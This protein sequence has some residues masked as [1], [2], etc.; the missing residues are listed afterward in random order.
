MRLKSITLVAAIA[1]LLTVFAGIFSY[2][3]LLQRMG[4]SGSAEFFV[5]QPI[6]IIANI[7]LTVFL[8]VLV[9]RQK[10]N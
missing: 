9:S 7:T 1:H 2:I 5:M 8:F 4:W 10:G 6:Y 3:R